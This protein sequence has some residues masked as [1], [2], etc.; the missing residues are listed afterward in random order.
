M[1]VRDAFGGSGSGIQD[2]PE[3]LTVFEMK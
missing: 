1:T 2:V 3:N